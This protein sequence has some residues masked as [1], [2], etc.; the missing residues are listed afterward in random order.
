M[1]KSGID[2]TKGKPKPVHPLVSAGWVVLII[3]ITVTMF[4]FIKIGLNSE[5]TNT[6]PGNN[7]PIISEPTPPSTTTPTTTPIPTPT[8]T[9][10]FT[11]TST[12]TLS[13]KT[14]MATL[15][16]CRPDGDIIATLP[17]EFKIATWHQEDNEN[18]CY[19]YIDGVEIVGGT[20]PYTIALMQG[21]NASVITSSLNGRSDFVNPFKVRRGENVDAFIY[22]QQYGQVIC[23]EGELYYPKYPVSIT[24]NY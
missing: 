16:V 12:P 11:P 7:P 17:A 6:P 3:V 5:I 10:T 22:Y 18:K 14:L 1:N 9:P 2:L 8:F 13:A 19:V 20:P 24:C 15:S 4:Y 21:D 23:W